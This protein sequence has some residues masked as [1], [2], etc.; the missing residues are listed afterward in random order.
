LLAALQQ[1]GAANDKEPFLHGKKGQIWQREVV[2]LI[3]FDLGEIRK[4]LPIEPFGHQ[5]EL[6]LIAFLILRVQVL[7]FREKVA[8]LF[9]LGAALRIHAAVLV[10]FHLLRRA[11]KDGHELDPTAE[12][13]VFDADDF[14]R[15]FLLRTNPRFSALDKSSLHLS[16]AQRSLLQRRANRV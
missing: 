12:Q 4:S 15:D 14:E 11:L 3:S 6:L 13:S 8:D 7:N 9:G 10:E 5:V 16:T 2:S 1:H